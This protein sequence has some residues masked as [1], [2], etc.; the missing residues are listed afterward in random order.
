MLGVVLIAGLLLLS[1]CTKGPGHSQP[2]NRDDGSVWSGK[3]SAYHDGTYIAHSAYL[4]ADGHGQLLTIT[5]RKG[6]ITKAAFTEHDAN[7]NDLSGQAFTPAVKSQKYPTRGNVYET[8]DN[9]LIRKQNAKDLPTI[10]EV[11]QLSRDFKKLAQTALN[12]SQKNKNSG[13][14]VSVDLEKKT[15][16]ATD[17]STRIPFNPQ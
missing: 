17:N 1:A 10:K 3:H 13:I 15:K 11:P 6:I 16:N 9:N 14:S 7:G 2:I 8:L 4:D 12:N 5:I